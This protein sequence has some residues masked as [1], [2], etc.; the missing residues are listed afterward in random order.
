MRHSVQIKVI[1]EKG[2][3]LLRNYSTLVEMPDGVTTS[4]FKSNIKNNLISLER[5]EEVKQILW[6]GNKELKDDEVVPFKSGLEYNLII[7]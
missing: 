6:L 5:F 1:I 7:K 4:N 3:K 2:E